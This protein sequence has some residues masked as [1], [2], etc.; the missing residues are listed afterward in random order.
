MLKTLPGKIL[1]LAFDLVVELRTERNIVN[2]T[3]LD[4]LKMGWE[5]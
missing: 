1:P 5:A 4:V 3:F 2:K